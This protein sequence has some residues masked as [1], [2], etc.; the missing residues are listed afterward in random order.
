MRK[1]WDLA[2]GEI[3]ATVGDQAMTCVAS[4]SDRLFAAGDA[5]GAVHVVELVELEATPE[6]K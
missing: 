1:V 3:L 4:I 5:G 2:S 6:V